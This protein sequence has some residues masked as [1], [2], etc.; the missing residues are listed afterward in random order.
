MQDQKLVQ[1][2][3]A[4]EVWKDIEGFEGRYQVSTFGN[5]KSL[6]RFRNGKNGSLVPIRESLMTPKV[7]RHGYATV[8]LRADDVSAQPSVHR[9]VAKAFIQNPENKPTVNHIDGVKLNNH[10][11]NL[12]WAT[13]SEQAVHSSET[14]LQKN[15]GQK[16]FSK[17]YIARVKQYYDENH[18]SIYELSKLFNMSE[19]TA[20]RCV[21]SKAYTEPLSDLTKSDIEAI[22]SLRKSGATLK[23]IGEIYSKSTSQIHRITRGESGNVQ[24]EYE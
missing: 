8:H 3:E 19:R 6:A 1:A 9:L 10:V 20:G 7:T 22:I 23:A 11:S 15:P 2:T 12:E 18:I 21:N 4:I 17:E 16:R 13:Q 24:Y 14:G 5:V